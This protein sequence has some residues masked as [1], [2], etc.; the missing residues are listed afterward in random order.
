M[1]QRPPSPN[2]AGSQSANDSLNLSEIRS[3]EFTLEERAT[4]LRVA[5]EA[6]VAAVEERAHSPAQAPAHL[7]APRG[8]FTTLYRGDQLRGCVGYIIPI[9]PLFQAVAETAQAAAMHDTRFTPVER[10][11]LAEIHVS[12]SV[13]SP[14]FPIEPHQ[15][16]IGRH[17]L[18]IRRD[19]RRGLLL[20]QVAT[21]HGWD[22]ETFLEQTCCKAGLPA[23]AWKQGAEI[24][25]FTAEIFGDAG[26]HQ[27]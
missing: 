24:E 5:H 1:W 17:G 16:E 11:E 27:F 8:V 12:L 25:A 15:I 21:E 23:N 14:T 26:L 19:G 22:T 18:V 4:L 3:A 2:H 9:R 7:S 20:P 6:I 10:H 13:L